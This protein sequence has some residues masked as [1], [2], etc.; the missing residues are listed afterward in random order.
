MGLGDLKPDGYKKINVRMI[1][2]V[3]HDLRHKARLVAGGHLTDPSQ[4]SNY[5][6]VVSLHSLRILITVAE[7]NGMTTKVADVGNAYLEAYTRE[8]V[9]VVASEGFGELS[10]HAYHRENA[11]RSKK[12]GSKVSRK[13]RRHPE[14]DG[15]HAMQ[16]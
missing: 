1:Y 8:M 2:T 15:I 7:L 13:V 12:F 5:S 6:G 10:G 16:G 3:K 4:D 9:Y 14:R 11:V